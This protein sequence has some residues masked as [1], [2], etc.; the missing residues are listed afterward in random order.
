MGPD[1][2]L[3]AQLAILLGPLLLVLVGYLAGSSLESRHFASIRERE[4]QFRSLPTITFETLPAGW[5]VE[6][7][8]LA[9]GNVVVSLDYFKRLLAGLR[10][11]VGGRIRALE[12][13]LDRGRRE[14][15]LRMQQQAV[16][17]GYEAVINVRLETSQLDSSGRSGVAG[18]EILAYGTAIKFVRAAV[19]EADAVLP[20]SA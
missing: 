4:E 14:A 16:Q 10:A 17:L 7:S 20:K 6:S 1:F 8:R 13:L 18:V 3:Y 5:R 9:T 12:P 19:P 11:V 15:I 2:E